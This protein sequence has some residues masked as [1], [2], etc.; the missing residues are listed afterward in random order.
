MS[1]EARALPVWD[2]SSKKLGMW[3][4]IVS[5]AFTFG[6]LLFAYAYSRV[7]NPD[8]P[9]PFH[10]WPTVVLAAAMSVCLLAASVAMAVA[11]R[12]M[13]RGDRK[14]AGG[15]ILATL[16][17]GAAFLALHL[18]GWMNLVRQQ[19]L[20][21]SGNPWGVPLFG[22][23]FF[24]LTGLHMAHVAAGL[25]YLGIVCQAVLRGRFQA[26]DVEV[27]GL[28]WQFVA[29]TWVFLFPLVYLMSAKV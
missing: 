13:N 2:G 19:H 11:V 23:T 16:G 24:A 9:A 17:G 15:W 12:A 10:V 7:A 21:P 27:A 8:W 18:A 26:V 1:S 5:D 6:A 25:V 29:V 20:T 22:G 3:L 14:A 4:F 28:Y